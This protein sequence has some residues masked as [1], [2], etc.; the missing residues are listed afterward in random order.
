MANLESVITGE[1]KT[2]VV[3]LA[4]TIDGAV[5]AS[6]LKRTRIYELIGLGQLVAKKAGRCTIIT[7]DSLQRYIEDLPAANIRAPKAA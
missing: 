1:A 5:K 7:A 3:P 2:H 6:G 4:Y